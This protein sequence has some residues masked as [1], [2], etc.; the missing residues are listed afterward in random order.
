MGEIIKIIDET[1]ISSAP[2]IEDDRIMNES[3]MKFRINDEEKRCIENVRRSDE[4]NRNN[5]KLCGGNCDI[6]GWRRSL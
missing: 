4:N 2:T 1:K 6:E 3:M 5:Q